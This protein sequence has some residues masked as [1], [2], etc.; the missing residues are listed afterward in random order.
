MKLSL[1]YHWVAMR[2]YQ[3]TRI[4][5]VLA[6]LAATAPIQ[7]H[8]ALGETSASVRSD[9]AKLQAQVGST[10]HA[11]Y[12][13]AVISLPSGTVVKEYISPA[14]TVFALSWHGLRPPDLSQ[15]LGRYYTAYQAALAKQ[16]RPRLHHLQIDAGGMVFE[17]HGHMRDMWGSAYLPALM[18]A[19]LSLQDLH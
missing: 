5:V 9:V 2:W 4:A 12:T 13:T 17:T 11:R 16:S 18:P 7:A 3:R 10:S 6:C 8:A 14:G 19:G 1:D 15:F